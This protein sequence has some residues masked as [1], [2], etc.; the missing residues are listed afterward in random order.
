MKLRQSKKKIFETGDIIYNFF[1]YQVMDSIYRIYNTVKYES[2]TAETE[3][4]FLNTLHQNEESLGRILTHFNESKM[5]EWTKAGKEVDMEKENLST[6]M[7]L[8]I[9]EYEKSIRSPIFNTLFSDFPQLILIQVQKLKT[10]TERMMVQFDKLLKTNQLNFELFA[11][12]PVAICFY[13]SFILWT[14]KKRN[15]NLE[16]NLKVY[17]R[18]VHV[19]LNSN[20]EGHVNLDHLNY[21]RLLILLIRLNVLVKNMKS[22][23]LLFLDLKELESQSYTTKQRLCAVDRIY[24][25]Y[26][27]LKI[28]TLVY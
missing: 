20:Q 11:L 23:E 18:D 15:Y 27:F 12:F 7:S 3:A 1:H 8:V 21:G 24:N 2:K 25:T 10:D 4:E 22:N 26:S 14:R 13:F 9:S 28:D 16:N 5:K 17:F 6:D 19:L